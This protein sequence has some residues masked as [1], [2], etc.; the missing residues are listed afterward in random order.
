MLTKHFFL[1]R[2]PEL[3]KELLVNHAANFV[4]S[5]HGAKMLARGIGDGLLTTVGAEHR[6]LR[7]L[8]QPAFTP[9]RIKHYGEQMLSITQSLVE[10][11]Q[12]GK[13]INV[14]REM[15]ELTVSIVAQIIFGFDEELYERYFDSVSQSLDVIQSVTLREIDVPIAIPDSLP[16]PH[17]RRRKK[18]RSAL[19][20]AIRTMVESRRNNSNA[21]EL[22][23]N[24]DPGDVIG[25]LAASVDD[26]GEKLSIDQIVEQIVTIYLAGHETTAN[27]LSWTLIELA[28]N[29]DVLQKLEAEIS[30]NWQGDQCKVENAEKLVYTEQVVMESLRHHPPAWSLMTRSPIK[31]D[32][33]AGLTFKSGDLLVVS[34][35]VLHHLD[36]YWPEPDRFDPE[37][38]SAANRE[39]HHKFSYLPFGAG[40]HICIGNHFAMLEAKLILATLIKNFT[41]EFANP[42]DIQ[43]RTQLTLSAKG[44]TSAKLRKNS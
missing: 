32:E 26:D 24:P 33:F 23:D 25:A 2:D 39:K 28:R 3:A 27:A 12:D 19:N 14:D 30:S 38:F 35:Y 15:R 8:V 13:T 43:E 9:L 17:I 20:T 40:A 36:S 5:P 34:P 6:R 22:G 1:I 11:W 31:K 41:F 7:K 18:A 21:S 37:R 42:H 44:D 10:H 29:P 4:K 16:L